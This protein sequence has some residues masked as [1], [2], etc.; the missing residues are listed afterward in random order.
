MTIGIIGAEG[1]IG[2]YLVKVFSLFHSVIEITRKNYDSYHRAKFDVLINANGNSKKYWAN[3]HPKEDF[4]ASVES[5]YNAVTNFRFKKYIHISSRDA[6]NDKI[7]TIYGY[8]KFIAEK[9][10]AKYCRDYSI[11]RLPAVIGLDSKKGVV[12]NIWHGETIYITKESTLI[13]M[14]AQTIAQELLDSFDDLKNIERFYP[15]LGITVEQIGGILK[16]DIMFDEE[17]E[18]L[19][20]ELYDYIRPSRHFKSSGEYLINTYN[21][22]ME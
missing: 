13:L 6:E 21:E 9:I 8:N 5:V 2:R 20:H 11:I 1:F 19:K 16:K 14:D 10:V 17:S 18:F 15:N 4:K 7:H 3:I 12:H 22:R